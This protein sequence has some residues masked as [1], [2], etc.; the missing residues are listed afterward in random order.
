LERLLVH[1]VD[2][3][4]V[5]GIIWAFVKNRGVALATAVLVGTLSLY[6]RTVFDLTDGLPEAGLCGLLGIVAWLGFLR[7]FR[8]RYY[9]LALGAFVLALL[10]SE[11]FAHSH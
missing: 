10:G 2:T 7:T 8:L 6:A 1:L 3:V 9:I 4:L 5:F 11:V